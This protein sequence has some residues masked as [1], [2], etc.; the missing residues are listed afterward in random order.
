MI[1]LKRLV[2]SVCARPAASVSSVLPVPAGAE[3]RHEV[4]VRVEQQVQREVLLAVAR[5]DAPHGVA[6]AAVVLRHFERRDFAVDLAHDR[7]EA[8]VL[9]V[10][11]ELVRVPLV[12]QRPAHAV[13][14]ARLLVPGLDVVAVRLPEVRGQRGHAGEQ[15]VRVLD[16]AVVVVVLR[17]HAE[18]RRLDAQ[19][20]VLGHQRDARA[21]QFHL[22]RERVAEQRV[23]DAVAV[24]GERVRA[25]PR[26]AAWSGSRAGPLGGFLPWFP[27]RPVGSSSPLSISSLV[28]FAISSSRNRLTCRTLRADSDRPFLPA[29]SSSSTP[30]G[31]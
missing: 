12:H 17:V 9:G 21:G 14:G 30:M 28:A 2:S 11:Q 5:G 23:V 31:R 20:D 19:V 4:D 27:E 1:S 3:D 29:S 18:D 7:L 13:V 16:R 6:L 15:Q 25:G 8:V 22:Q 10:V 24:A 26:P